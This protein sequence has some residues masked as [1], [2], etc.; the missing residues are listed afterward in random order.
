[1][2]RRLVGAPGT[3][4]AVCNWG[5]GPNVSGEGQQ[6]GHGCRLP[7]RRCGAAPG[8][9]PPWLGFR[10]PPRRGR[11]LKSPP[12]DPLFGDPNAAWRH[13]ERYD[14]DKPS[15]ARVLADLAA[16]LEPMDLL[17]APLWVLDVERSQLLW[18]NPRASRSGRW[19]TSKRPAA[20][21]SRPPS[22]MR[23]T[24]S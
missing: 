21:M 2:R 12:E 1:M 6:S 16:R 18:A 13:A 3:D 9:R 11:S 23:S 22:R 17:D 15:D 8:E 4:R 5:S 10:G 19:W 24:A 20:L 14:P 7:G